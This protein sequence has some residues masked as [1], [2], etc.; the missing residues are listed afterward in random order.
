MYLNLSI[1][2]FPIKR[3]LLIELQKRRLENRLKIKNF[4]P[5]V[6]I[7]SGDHVS[8]EPYMDLLSRQSV[9]SRTITRALGARRVVLSNFVCF[10]RSIRSTQLKLIDQLDRYNVVR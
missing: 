4:I 10:Y 8:Y 3:F 2:S 5:R 7:R 6:V 9:G 1:T